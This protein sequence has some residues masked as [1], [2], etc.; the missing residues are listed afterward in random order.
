LH[1]SFVTYAASF[2]I[3]TSPAN[4]SSFVCESTLPSLYNSSAFAWHCTQSANF[5]GIRSQY[6]TQENLENVP[7][8][9]FYSHSILPHRMGEHNDGI[10]FQICLLFTF[11]VLSGTDPR[12]N[13]VFLFSSTLLVTFCNTLRTVDN[14]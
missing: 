2:R 13:S 4:E 5:A 7:F 1:I 8:L 12:C 9:P 10:Y 3:S 14:N 11:D 6:L